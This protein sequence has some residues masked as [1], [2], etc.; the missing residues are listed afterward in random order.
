MVGLIGGIDPG[1]AGAIA[2][3]DGFRVLDCSPTPVTPGKG[4][5]YIPALML[6][7]LKDYKLRGVEKIR[8]EKPQTRSGEG[9]SSAETVGYGRGLWVMA[10]TSLEIPFEFVSASEWTAKYKFKRMERTEAKVVHTQ[11]AA[12][13][14]PSMA[15]QLYGPRGG[16]IDGKA[17][18]LL[19]ALSGYPDL[20]S[21]ASAA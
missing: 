5:D 11:R 20:L 17:D 1:K 14:F 21:E 19:I 10:L 4:G 2:L 13:L 15:K 8:I 7:I 12:Q 16:V 18:A 9:V 3:L 6:D